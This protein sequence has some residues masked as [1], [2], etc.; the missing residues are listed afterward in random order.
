MSVEF[1]N[2]NNIPDAERQAFI[3]ALT[4]NCLGVSPIRTAFDPVEPGLIDRYYRRK[5]RYPDEM[6]ASER[7]A[8]AKARQERSIYQL[9]FEAG[10][11]LASHVLRE[12]GRKVTATVGQD[13][14]VII[15]QA[16]G[17]D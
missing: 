14:N 7:E 4:S 1:G 2:Q 11:E 8:Q 13:N 5:K 16:E 3:K 12:N 10:Q 9:A 15:K 17:V 6:A